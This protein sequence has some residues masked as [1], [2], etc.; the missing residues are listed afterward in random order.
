[1]ATFGAKLAGFWNHPAGPKTIHFWAP[2]FKWAISIANVADFSR[3]VDQVSYPQQCA[4]TA[5]GVIWSRFSTQIV[6]VNYNLLSV[7]AFM[8]V[9]GGY[10]LYRKIT[11]DY[12]PSEQPLA[13]EATPSEDD[14]KKSS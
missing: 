9:T 7:N 13:L 12:F 4:V 6:P 14:S 2:T 3:P 8:A 5:T 10:Q 1:M 11:H